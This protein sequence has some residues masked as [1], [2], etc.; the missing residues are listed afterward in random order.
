MSIT[1]QTPIVVISYDDLVYF[2]IHYPKKKD[3]DN[4]IDPI[5]H[6]VLQCIEQAFGR[7]K[8]TT[9]TSL[10]IVAVTNVPG[11]GE[12]RRRL[13]P[14]ARELALL[15]D[16]SDII[17]VESNYQTGWS[18]GKEILAN[19]NQRPDVAKGSFYANPFQDDLDGRDLNYNRTDIPDEIKYKY[20]EFFAPNVWPSS[21]PEFRL[22]MLDLSKLIMDVGRLLIRPCDVYVSQECG[23]GYNPSTLTR[24]LEESKFAKARLLHY[25]PIHRSDVSDDNCSDWCGWHNDHVRNCKL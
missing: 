17:H 21:W 22:A 13:L 9:E 4:N 12:K 15:E 18:H 24:V 16:K 20:P 19:D 8:P 25:F 23:P 3:S 7:T 5:C 14:M 11:L 1:I 2:S 6:G 10:G